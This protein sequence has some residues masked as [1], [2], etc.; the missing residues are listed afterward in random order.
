[1]AQISTCV[2]DTGASFATFEGMF[3]SC[4]MVMNASGGRFTPRSAVHSRRRT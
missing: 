1:V 3:P 2:S 4:S